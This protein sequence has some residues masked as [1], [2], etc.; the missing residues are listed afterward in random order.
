[1]Y[2]TWTYDVRADS[3][4]K[5]NPKVEPR[6]NN[7][8]RYAGMAYDSLNKVHILFGGSGKGAWDSPPTDHYNDTW[9]YDAKLNTWTEMKPRE[10]PPAGKEHALFAYD[11]EHNLT[12][13][14]EGGYRGVWVYRYKRGRR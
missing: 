11:P 1:M 12:L 4:Q 2:T 13:M 9:V 8:R 6:G 7:A 10:S 14:V 5:M 3:W